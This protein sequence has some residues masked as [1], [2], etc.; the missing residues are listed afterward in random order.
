MSRPVN[1]ALA[2]LELLQS[3]PLIGGAELARR[4]GVSRRTVRRYIG[5]LEDIGIPIRAERGRDGGYAL[6]QGFKL[7]P[8][9]FSPDEA[10][11]LSIG[12]RAAAQLGL[13]GVAPAAHSA[14]I[15]LERVMPEATRRQVQAIH[16]AVA[17]DLRRS[18]GMD[19]SG[20][21]IEL[22]TAARQQ[23][24]VRM[25][26]RTPQQTESERDFDSYA[27]AYRSGLW[28]AVG[29]CHLRRDLR[30]FRL[31]RI[32]SLAAL[33]NSFERPADFDVLAYMTRTIAT[34]PRTHEILVALHTDIGAARRAILGD[35]ATL[36]DCGDFVR[37]RGQAD[38]LA[39]FARELARLPFAFEILSPDALRK[40]LSAL[41]R[42]LIAR[43][44]RP[45]ASA[46][47]IRSG[48][49]GRPRH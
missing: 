42:D 47:R 9:M 10:L 33:P 44:R 26:Y 29:H 48:D 5:T 16:D 13:S 2:V 19:T 36:E 35:V 17:L 4:L 6:V 3:Q 38:D 1:R 34:L 37:L 24:R 27:V 41:G 30:S 20:V 43:S 31:D 21:L 32:L 45:S 15:K 28:Y 23:R 14:Q 7:P 18:Q 12:L 40:T 8:M 46:G 49:H 39:W 11:A 25:R 22:A